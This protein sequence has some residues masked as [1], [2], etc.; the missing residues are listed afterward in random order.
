MSAVSSLFSPDGPLAK[1]IPGFSPRAAQSQMADAVALACKE[2]H[3]LVV[4]AGTGTGKTFAY[5]APAL[6]SKGKTI[7]STGTKTLQEQLFLRDL[8]VLKKALTSGKRVAMLKGRANYLCTQR[9]EMHSEMAFSQDKSTM[10]DMARIRHWALAT[11]S[12]DLGELGSIGEDS[13]A[14]PMVTSTVDNC[15]GKDCPDY[16]ECY[17]VKARKR[18]LEADLVVVNHHL[19]F[20]DL[21]LKDT[22]FGELVPSADLVILDEAH[23]LPDIASSYFGESIST[24]QL[25]EL[26]K[27][28]ENIYR[29]ELRDLKQ[30]SEMAM[31]IQRGISD[32]RLCFAIDPEKGNWRYQLKQS[33]VQQCLNKINQDLELLYKI[34]KNSLSRSENLDNCFERCMKL[35]AVWHKMQSVDETGMSFWYETSKQFISLHLTPLDVAAKFSEQMEN[36]QAAW[37]FTSATLTVNQGFEHF[38]RQLGLDKAQTLLLPSPF[39]YENQALLCVP[40]YLPAANDKGL[41]AHLAGIALQLITAARGRSFLLFTSYRMMNMVADVL[42]GET[43]LPLLVQGSTSKQALLDAFNQQRESVLLGTASFWEGV[44]VRGDALVCVMID[45]LPFAAPDEPLLQARIEDCKNKGGDP[46]SQVQLPQAVITLKQGVGRLIRDVKDK[47]VLVICDSRL[48]NRQYAS[49]FLKSLP[50]MRRSR[51]LAKAVAVL[52]RLDSE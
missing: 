6:M 3:A 47:G 48:V 41:A 44:D 40:R 13:R 31:R 5:L 28:L 1:A 12:G 8:P 17:L 50:A 16:Q 27:D 43:E 51:D 38:N 33:K 18:A 35:Q 34:I 25:N 2:K 45:K 11:D 20:A 52:E 37:V 49:V 15:L 39:D 9:L 42:E 10:A 26:C 23:Q 14:L 22:G 21:A 4:E 7:V 24:R 29:T 32:F 46:F 36:M 30:L 19:F